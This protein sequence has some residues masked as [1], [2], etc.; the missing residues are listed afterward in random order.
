MDFGGDFK[1]AMSLDQSPLAMPSGVGLGG[2]A[3]LQRRQD[4]ISEGGCDDECDNDGVHKG[5]V[6]TV[7]VMLSSLSFL[8]STIYC[9]PYLRVG[10]QAF[11]GFVV[12]GHL[13]A[14]KERGLKIGG[15]LGERV[16][17]AVWADLPVP[18][19][20]GPALR[21][22]FLLSREDSDGQHLCSEEVSRGFLRPSLEETLASNHSRSVG[23]EEE[24]EVVGSC[25]I[26]FL[27]F[28]LCLPFVFPLSYTLICF[29][30]SFVA[31]VRSSCLDSSF[32]EWDVTSGPAQGMEAV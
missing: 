1:A 10:G 5:L 21:Q 13:Q 3:L 16:V 29:Y 17:C 12:V 31:R 14:G 7:I 2:W 4:T 30:F 22:G 26:R 32:C 24:E 6:F 9:F 11:G 19:F 23:E 20:V 28:F 15:W 18:S 27:L 25:R 8:T